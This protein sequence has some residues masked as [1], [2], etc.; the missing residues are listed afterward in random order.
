[1]EKF[2]Y[3]AKSNAPD[4]TEA[5]EEVIMVRADKVSHFEMQSA[6][7]LDVHFTQDVGQVIE[8]ADAGD[9]N[10]SI[11]ALDITSGK[12]KE[13]LEAIAGAINSASAINSPMVVIADGANS[14]FIHPD[15][16]ACV[17][18]DVIDR[19]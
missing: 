7:R 14:K 3:F 15:I 18:I 10:R 19:P 8:D 4:A 16:T 9:N 13:V 1:M 5:D 17:G 6:T 11:A 12:H 2:L